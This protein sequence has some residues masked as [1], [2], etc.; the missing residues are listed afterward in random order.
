MEINK[1]HITIFLI[2]TFIY[3]LILVG[4]TFNQTAIANN[5]NKMPVLSPNVY[6]TE[7][8]FTHQNPEEISHYFLTDIF[9]IGK[10]VY[11][12][13]DFFLLIGLPLYIIFS[14]FLLYYYSETRKRERGLQV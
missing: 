13:G 8:H 12:I 3:S 5:G 1:K 14:V 7:T 2:T 11:S 9:H 10:N 6:E 4:I